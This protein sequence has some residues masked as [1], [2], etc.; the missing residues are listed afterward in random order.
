[1]L[2]KILSYTLLILL[3]AFGA[4]WIAN[5]SGDMVLEWQDYQLTTSTA[6]FVFLLIILIIFFA[7]ILPGVFGVFAWPKRWLK[8]R[9]DKKFKAGLEHI[10]QVI[11]STSIG[12]L[13]AAQA[14]LNKA[15]K[16][17]AGMAIIPLLQT[18][19]A[20][21]KK[22]QVLLESSLHELQKHPK[23]KA[24]AAKGLAELHMRK[25]ELF[26]ALNFAEQVRELEPGNKQSFLMSL[27]LYLKSKQ[28]VFAESLLEDAKKQKVIDKYELREYGAILAYM[29]SL[30]EEVPAEDQRVYI[31]QA[32][33]LAPHLEP[34]FLRFIALYN[35]GEHVS[36]AVKVLKRSWEGCFTPKLFAHA[37]EIALDEKEKQKLYH[38][39]LGY[40]LSGK[41]YAYLLLAD[42]EAKAGRYQDASKQ[43]TLYKEEL[44]KNTP[45]ALDV[46]LPVNQDLDELINYA[47]EVEEKIA[48]LSWRC[49]NCGHEAQIYEVICSNCQSVGSYQGQSA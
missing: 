15:K 27:A 24:L 6:N 8:A 1:M 34:I 39:L 28:F 49:K 42:S 33:E 41:P 17:Y 9:E 21:A 20:A 37:R 14:H 22:D 18:Q 12:D 30:Q 13:K 32:Y 5:G 3:L 29:R 31:S 26:P 4:Y 11:I 2:S 46:P 10:T 23:T 16:P 36:Q 25:G 40:S 48:K 7:V 35:E 19:I 43:F 47:D 38:K 44:E 45:K